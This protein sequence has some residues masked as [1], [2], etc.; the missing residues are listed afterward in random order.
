MGKHFTSGGPLGRVEGEE[1]DE[2]LRA[3]FGEKGEFGTDDGAGGFRVGRKTEGFRIGEAFKARPRGFGGNAAEFEDLFKC[4]AT[5]YA[6]E[7]LGG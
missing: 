3:G 7:F 2:K 5:S 1:R 6:V 4:L